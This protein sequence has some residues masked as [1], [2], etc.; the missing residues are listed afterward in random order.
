MLMTQPELEKKVTLIEEEE[1]M[2]SSNQSGPAIQVLPLT[3]RDEID[4]FLLGSI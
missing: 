4:Q 1:N 2:S 3:P